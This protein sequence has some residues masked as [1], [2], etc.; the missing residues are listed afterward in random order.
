[1]FVIEE[2]FE[3]WWLATNLNKITLVLSNLGIIKAAAG[4]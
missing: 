3:L 2:H 1:M 4:I